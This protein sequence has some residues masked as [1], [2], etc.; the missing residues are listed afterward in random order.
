LF[1]NELKMSSHERARLLT[2]LLHVIMVTF[3]FVVIWGPWFA[4]HHVPESQFAPQAILDARRAP[5]DALLKELGGYD[6]YPRLPWT[7]DG[8]L[9]KVAEKLV[10]G[11]IELPRFPAA[12]LAIPFVPS[13]MASG[14]TMWQLF[15]HSLG[16]PRVLLD[17]YEKTG[18][19]Q[20]LQAA[21][22]YL[23]AY[24]AYE[25]SAWAP[26][27]FLWRD[28]WRT[29]VRNDHAVASRVPVLTDFWR[30]YRT[31]P[32]YQPEV[33]EA[34]LRMAARAAYLVTDPSRFTVATNHGVMQNLAA[35]NV[36]LAF[37]GLPGVEGHCR[38]ALSRL[39][40]QLAF[41]ISDEGFILEH[42]P[43]YQNFSLRLIGIALRYSTLSNTEIPESWLWKYHA[44][45]RVFAG[46][47]RPD[48]SLPV[49][50]DT[51][52]GPLGPG[53]VTV[54]ID[55]QGRASSA[56][57]RD[58]IPEDELLLAPVAGY[59]VWWDGLR[60]WPDAR[61]IAQTA[62]AWSHFP[63][64]GHKHA[65]ELSLSMWAR[66]TAW[67]GNVGYW[68][69]DSEGRTLA[70]SWEGSNAPHL[71]GEPAEAVRET[72]LRYHGAD[73]TF[74]VFDVE[75]RGPGLY[76]A[77][78]QVIHVRPYLWVVI[79]TSSGVK[80]GRTSTT[81]TTAPT[82]RLT[83]NG[84]RGG[85][86]LTDASSGHLL[87]AYFDGAPNTTRRV[88]AGSLSPFGGWSVVGPIVQPA[89]AVVVEG[90]ADGSWQLTS[91]NLIG[92]PNGAGLPERGLTEP[93]LMQRWEGADSWEL[94]LQTAAE[95][96]TLQRRD[97]RI[98]LISAAERTRTL[99][100]QAGP[101]V[102]RA[103]AA[104]RAAFAEASRKYG[105]ADMSSTYRLKVTTVLLVGLLL[106]GVALRVIRQFR[107]QVA[108][109]AEVV[110]AGSWMLASFYLVMIRAQ[111]L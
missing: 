14:P 96:I 46:L 107:P 63:G 52:A 70:E 65:D 48:G 58:W 45:Q 60:A 67:W 83:E 47:R 74:A 79:D 49:F 15:V 25:R 76:Q 24:D 78:R 38:L 64:M 97:G 42:S 93:P 21:A 94:A 68:P 106:N 62:M 71:V 39:D 8:Q 40:E 4:H 33:G 20:F 55:G 17:A 53:P 22:D 86:R 92:N 43:G 23:V 95:S 54:V 72:R 29:F 41:F 99:R 109:S 82:V 2:R 34:V 80:E 56:A 44:A 57:L 98:H 6:L 85:Y 19:A 18:R 69:Y 59:A 13:T 108:L 31:S 75:R 89:S 88:I 35:C 16:L 81:W 12:T 61:A 3:V 11:Q 102:S 90:P 26:S 30:L 27:G 101:D 7:D 37:P 36:A 66:G 105:A 84:G 10:Q 28:T 32:S 1:E 73:Q 100:L 9:V 77:R 5:D 87:Q 91:W 111:L 50:G 110:L 103:R 104:L 51:G